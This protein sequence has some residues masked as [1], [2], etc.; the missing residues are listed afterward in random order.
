MNLDGPIL[1]TELVK[2]ENKTK[3]ILPPLQTFRKC[4]NIFLNEELEAVPEAW[5]LLA[6]GRETYKALAYIYSSKTII[7]IPHPTSSRGHFQE[8]IK[9]NSLKNILSSNEN[10]FFEEYGSIAVWLPDLLK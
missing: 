3:G 8:M 9:G 4:I 7:G 1:W 2:C 6:V 10:L 5:P